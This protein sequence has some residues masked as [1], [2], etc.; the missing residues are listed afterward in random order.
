MG[1][2][3][4]CLQVWP[5]LWLFEVTFGYNKLCG[6]TTRISTGVTDTLSG[7]RNEAN[8]SALQLFCPDKKSCIKFGSEL[9]LKIDQTCRGQPV[10]SLL[11]LQQYVYSPLSKT[12]LQ[13]N[14]GANAKISTIQTWEDTWG[15]PFSERSLR[16]SHW[17][18]W[19][20]SKKTQSEQKERFMIVLKTFWDTVWYI[21][22][23]SSKIENS[24]KESLEFKRFFLCEV[25][26]KV[27]KT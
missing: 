23:Y 3:R 17:G 4:G 1:G 9:G 19:E 7:G 8:D 18:L 26:N 16:R 11:P 6:W 5:T 20:D 14:S 24:E 10:L 25:R 27:Y 21:L 12:T 2:W 13:Q 22:V 15:P